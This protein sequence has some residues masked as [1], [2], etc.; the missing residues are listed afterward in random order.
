MNKS[1]SVS[2]AADLF[3]SVNINER[4]PDISGKTLLTQS[5]KVQ[6]EAQRGGQNQNLWAEL[7]R[8][9]RISSLGRRQESVMK[10]R[11]GGKFSNMKPF[12]FIC[13]CDQNVQDS[14]AT[15]RRQ[16]TEIIGVIIWSYERTNYFQSH[17]FYILFI[18]LKMSVFLMNITVWKHG[19]TTFFLQH[20]SA[21][22]VKVLGRL[23]SEFSSD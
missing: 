9:E 7:W 20:L 10:Y 23:W 5:G 13:I 3:M 2:T 19:N 16:I 15:I 22:Q 14:E 1:P 6:R 21:R 11:R 8:S 12:G 18:H 17:I 4:R